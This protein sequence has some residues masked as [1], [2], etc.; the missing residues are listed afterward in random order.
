M[1]K[2]STVS[3]QQATNRAGE[4]PLLVCAASAISLLSF[5][6]YFQRG[7]I[8]LYGDAVAHINIARR[9]FDSQTPGLLQLGT[10][11]L[12]LPHLLMVPLL[13][14]EF[15]WRTGIG[16]SIP[17][18]I[19]YVVSVVGIFRLAGG[20]LQTSEPGRR[21]ARAGAWIAAL[22]FGAN[23]NLI[24]VQ[25]TAMTETLYLATSI[26]AA[27]F[28]LRWIESLRIGPNR[29]EQGE[30]SL[31]KCALCLAAA[32][33]I[34]YDG[35]FLA[36]AAGALVA[37][38]A[39]RRWSDQGLRRAAAKLLLAIAA[40]PVLWLAYNGVFYGDPL[41]FAHG[42]YSAKA[43]E[44]RTAKPG[45]PAHPGAGNLIVAG[46]FFLKSAQLNM[47]PGNWG[48]IW[49]VIALAGFL[50]AKRSLRTA[51]VVLLLWVPLLFYAV[52]IAYGGVPL[53][54]PTWW[55][56]TWYNIRYGLQFL[57]LFA[58][59]AG[60]AAALAIEFLSKRYSARRLPLAGYGAAIAVIAICY[61][62]VWYSQPL[63]FTEA[64]VNSRT[65]LAL[66][67]S[68]ARVVS[69]LPPTS[70]YL[71]YVGD[72]VGLFQQAGIPL[73]QVINE[74]NHRPW[75]RPKDP[76]GLWERAL[77]NP[78][79]FVEFVI[80]Y[81]GDVV[82]EKVEKKNLELLTEIHTTGQPHARIYAA[83]PTLNQSR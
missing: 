30:A 39:L 11:W 9:V 43:I 75:M 23:P 10:V 12:P 60:L 25:A 20:M 68:V 44:Q 40:A 51:P 26:W 7:E 41:E 4:L 69:V 1:K 79:R 70:R 8:L 81:D 63:C 65:K 22:T 77:A 17:S 62:S 59:A 49:I 37:T 67:S 27:V 64:W 50:F 35:W 56:H 24:Y 61:A 14:S 78:G 42:P 82:D 73:R 48:R 72:H 21:F 58:V 47:A 3:H 33:L 71:M 53:F 6:Y 54:V 52:S 13:V 32:E 15:M 38:I 55:P 29:E 5:L 28:L 45:Y 16:G 80:A 74:G 66:E 31:W 83:H 46:S 18:M 2:K 36:M 57:P 34:R 76:D 19:A